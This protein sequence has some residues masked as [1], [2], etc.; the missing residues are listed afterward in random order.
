MIACRAHFG[1][2]TAEVALRLR[3]RVCLADLANTRGHGENEKEEFSGISL[4]IAVIIRVALSQYFVQLGWLQD[5]VEYV[6][7]PG[8]ELEQADCRRHGWRH[9]GER[10]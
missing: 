6:C 7:R 10:A 3:G 4:N 1:D 2:G 5:R 9:G 8:K